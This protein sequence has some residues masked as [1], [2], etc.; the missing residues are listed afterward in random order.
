MNISKI[1]G[2]LVLYTFYVLSAEIPL[3]DEGIAAYYSPVARVNQKGSACS[4]KLIQNNQQK[5]EVF[6]ESFNDLV[7]QGAVYID[8]LRIAAEG[9]MLQVLK[10]IDLSAL[11]ILVLDIANTKNNDTVQKFLQDKGYKFIRVVNNDYYR[12]IKYP[13]EFG[14]W[15]ISKELFDCIRTLLP[16]GKTLLELGSGWASEEFSKYYTVYSIEHDQDW[17]DKYTTNY[18]YAPITNGWY[19]VEI[20][21]KE[22]PAHYD[23][24]L[25]DGP[26]GWIGRGGFYTYLSLFNTNVPIIFDDVN[27]PAEYELMVNVATFLHKKFVIFTDSSNKQFGVVR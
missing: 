8:Y 5:P 16:V 10:S 4:I 22:L 1:V 17:V 18:I 23:L 13:R 9:N 11:Q 7:E 12:F 3:R 21:K 24:I 2:C 19:D 20:L 15:S 14:G 26:P 27:R 6:Y 25:V